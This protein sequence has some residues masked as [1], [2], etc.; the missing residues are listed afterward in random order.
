[1]N[2]LSDIN[3]EQIDLSISAFDHSEPETDDCGLPENPIFSDYSKYLWKGH[4]RS[5]GIQ[6]NKRLRK[7]IEIKR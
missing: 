6:T 7:S 3:N 2:N 1:M 4:I 5:G